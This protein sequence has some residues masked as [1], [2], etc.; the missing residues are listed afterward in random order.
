MFGFTAQQIDIIYRFFNREHIT[1]SPSAPP[2]A[3][4]PAPHAFAQTYRSFLHS[5]L[6]YS[7]PIH[8]HH[9]SQYT[10]LDN[11]AIQWWRRLPIAT[12]VKILQEAEHTW[13]HR[14][15]KAVPAIQVS[16]T[17]EDCIEGPSKA[18]GIHMRFSRDE[19]LDVW[20]TAMFDHKQK[21]VKALTTL[22]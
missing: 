4:L 15:S 7:L 19:E 16:N 13:K 21:L 1:A 2:L 18:G 5:F 3:S 11:T 9:L 8:H 6:R 20:Y 22:A 14:A 17:F 10:N 12:S